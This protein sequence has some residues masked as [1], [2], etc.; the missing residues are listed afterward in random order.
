[1]TT[2]PTVPPPGESPDYKGDLHLGEGTPDPE[3]P[4]NTGHGTDPSLAEN[5]AVPG[6]N[7]D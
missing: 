2:S 5:E 4:I 6:S 3:G 1:M 7:E